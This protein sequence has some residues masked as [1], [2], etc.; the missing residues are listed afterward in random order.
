MS[1]LDV[2]EAPSGKDKVGGKDESKLYLPHI[3]TCVYC[4]LLTPA[5]FINPAISKGVVKQ[6]ECSSNDFISLENQIGPHC[7]IS[8]SCNVF[9]GGAH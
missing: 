5:I 9:T 6:W 7:Q 4:A 2:I 1:P 8:P 3:F